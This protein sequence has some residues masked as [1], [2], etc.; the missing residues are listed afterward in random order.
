MLKV[1]YFTSV[2]VMWIGFIL[3]VIW[4]LVFLFGLNGGAPAKCGF[5][6][7]CIFVLGGAI[8]NKINPVTPKS[9]E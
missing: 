6:S 2:A 3:F 1:I 5:F 4:L 7:L 8:A 9:E